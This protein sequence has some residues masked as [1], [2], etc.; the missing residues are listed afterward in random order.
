MVIIILNKIK[1]IQRYCVTKLV[2][3]GD[4]FRSKTSVSPDSAFLVYMNFH[5]L[6]GVEIRNNVFILISH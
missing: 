6:D 4:V 2:R 3:C 1:D 5:E